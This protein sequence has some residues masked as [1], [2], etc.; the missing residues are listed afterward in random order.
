MTT[1]L[2]KGDYVAAVQQ[3]KFSE[4]EREREHPQTPST[5]MH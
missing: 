2:D 3:F 1:E 4:Y 5:H